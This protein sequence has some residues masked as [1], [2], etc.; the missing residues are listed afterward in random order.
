MNIVTD[1][2]HWLS[3]KRGVR[4]AREGGHTRVT[5][6][7]KKKKKLENLKIEKKGFRHFSQPGQQVF[8]AHRLFLA[9][10]RGFSGLES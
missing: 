5:I 10:F 3:G 8:W 2:R 4:A 7:S 1:R 9:G 6:V